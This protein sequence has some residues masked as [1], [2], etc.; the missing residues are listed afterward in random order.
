MAEVNVRVEL[1]G[2]V[3]TLTIDRPKALNALNS[4]T[5]E[6]LEKAVADVAGHPELARASSSPAAGRRPSSP[7]PTS[8]R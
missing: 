4:R 7:A 1:E 8:P 6:E 5:L 3:A 2:P